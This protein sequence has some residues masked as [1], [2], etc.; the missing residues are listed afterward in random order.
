M[1][2]SGAYGDKILLPTWA[3]NKR[4]DAFLYGNHQNFEAVDDNKHSMSGGGKG[5][6][7]RK[8]GKG[9][10]GGKEDPG[11]KELKGKKTF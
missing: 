1:A 6:L 4:K 2:H 11:G 8:Q 7:G 5:I 3:L 10:M 9:G